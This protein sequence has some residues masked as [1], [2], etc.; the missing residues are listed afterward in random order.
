MQTAMELV[1]MGKVARGEGRM[2]EA[3]ACYVSAA[4]LLL[5]EEEMVRWAH[6]LR[7]VADLQRELGMLDEAG[8]NIGAVVMF[9][10][11]H[12]TGALEMGN[13]LRVAA[14]VEDAAGRDAREIWEETLELYEEVGVQAG[15]DEVRRKL[16]RYPS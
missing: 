8:K 16:G 7:H 6:T 5:E 15:V 4:D 13:S 10:R 2:D 14:L 1:A 12:G 3:L 9:Y 11:E